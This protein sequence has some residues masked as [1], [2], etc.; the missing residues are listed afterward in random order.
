[1]R[2]GMTSGFG[3]CGFMRVRGGERHPGGRLA[4]TITLPG[5]RPL[6]V[7][8]AYFDTV[9]VREENAVWGNVIYFV[10]KGEN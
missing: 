10:I 9:I 1:M 4:M 8:K 3:L 6:P 5:L 2:L 7:I